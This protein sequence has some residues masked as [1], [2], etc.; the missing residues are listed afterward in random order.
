MFLYEYINLFTSCH[1]F[2]G[3]DGSVRKLLQIRRFIGEIL[4]PVRSPFRN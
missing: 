4:I 2:G 1:H 3:L